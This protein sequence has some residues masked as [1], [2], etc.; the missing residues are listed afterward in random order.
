MRPVNQLPLVAD[1]NEALALR[2]RGEI[3][4]SPPKPR[5]REVRISPLRYSSAPNRTRERSRVSK[6]GI[7]RALTSIATGA[8]T[9]NS[10]GAIGFCACGVAGIARARKPR[11]RQLQEAAAAETCAHAVTNAIGAG[12]PDLAGAAP[13]VSLNS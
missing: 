8:A 3:P 9:V 6:E 13:W 10:S 4:D 7:G 1:G 11:R 12:E 5:N 2:R